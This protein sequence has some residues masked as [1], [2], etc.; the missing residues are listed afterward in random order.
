[1]IGVRIPKD[2]R[3]YKEKVALGMSLRQLLSLI[4]GVVIVAPIYYFGRKYV[5]EEII[6]WVTVLIAVPIIACGF[7]SINGMPL[8]RFIVRL[9]KNQF[10]Y[11]RKRLFKSKI[12]LKRVKPPVERTKKEQE[13]ISES[14]F[15][16]LFLIKESDERGEEK[17]MK[18]IKDE[19]LLTVRKS[20]K[21]RKKEKKLHDKKYNK[22]QKKHEKVSAKDKKFNVLKESA[23]NIISKQERD[24]EYIYTRKESRVVKKYKAETQKRRKN[25]V[26]KGVTEIK[27]KNKK[28]E[29]R[30]KAKTLIPKTA[31]ATLPYKTA[32]EDGLFE[33]ED[34]VYSKTFVLRNINFKIA[35]ELEQEQTFC[36]WGEFLN[37]FADD[38]YFSISIDNRV[39]SESEM[40]ENIHYRPT[41]DD[42]D[43]H[44]TEYNKIM[45]KAMEKSRKN[46]RQSIY[47]T[48][49]LSAENPYEANQKF[50][51]YERN[52]SN[53]LKTIGSACHLMTTTERLELIH[54]KMRSG[55]EGT[56]HIDYDF[57]ER[58]GLSS[59]DYVAPTSFSCM[60][61]K[62]YFKIDND[63][64]RTM[65]ISNMPTSL[66][67]DFI[68]EISDVDFP[69]THTICIQPI[70]PDKALKMVGRNYAGMEKDEL[71]YE[72]AAAKSGYS[73]PFL[74]RSLKQAGEQAEIL[75]DDIQNK[76]QKLFFV[77]IVCMVYGST[78]E[79][80]DANAAVL[81]GIARKFTCQLDNFDYQQE[82]GYKICFPTGINPKGKTYVDKA[83]TTEAAAIF[84]P[85]TT[86][87]LFQKHGYYYGINPLSN[88]LIMVDRFSFK[89]PSGFILG[90]SGSGKSFAC[91]REIINILLHDSKTNV[92][93]IDPENEYTT[94]CRMFGG[95]VINI[96]AGSDEHI[97]PMDMD[98]NYGLDENDNVEFVDM[99]TKKKKALAKKS[100]YI[101]SIVQSM[102]QDDNG[103]ILIT[104]A[105][106]SIVDRCVRQVYEEYL[107]QNFDEEYL[108][109]L[110][111]LWRAIAAERD[112][113]TEAAIIAESMEYFVQGS[114]SV[115]AQK[116][117]V[118]YNNRFVAFDIKEL[119]IQLTQ[120]GLLIILD[121]IWN[122]MSANAIHQVKTYCYADEIHVLFRNDYAASY[123][124][125]LYKRGRKFGLCITGITQDVEDLLENQM[126]RGMLS[127][128]DF[129]L[130][131]AQKT[132]NLQH[133][134]G[135]LHI[136]DDE[137][138]FV[139]KSEAGSG[140]LFAEQSIV[141]FSDHFP[142]TSYLYKLIS[143]KFGEKKSYE[144]IKAYVDDIMHEQQIHSISNETA[145]ENN[146]ETSEDEEDSKITA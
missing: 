144:E 38:V 57:L 91:K 134:Q 55:K 81:Q 34:G 22:N 40:Y 102:M 53:N 99:E 61:K 84:I 10:V 65:Y 106:K 19:D 98:E 88:N 29:K 110:V 112:V 121:F 30:R 130:M 39:I 139:T 129:I 77:T 78:K 75:L 26:E 83:L 90:S 23:E 45:D 116:T 49:S 101:M 37:Y 32:Y 122:R 54:D 128:S 8:E 127:N 48:L 15:E 120:I 135:L 66:T 20:R 111:D 80:L 56:F 24:P 126:A 96:S 3:E 60:D 143:T 73:K 92:L 7:F 108:P 118:D 13:Y 107:I 36:K 141:P 11:P 146:E 117:N 74:P 67:T 97:N 43:V 114:M 103:T 133:L 4:I 95:T 140:L 86:I 136:S 145:A 17:E 109:T 47:L 124:R 52:I 50:G 70:A 51:R 132:E 113:S 137:A 18:D 94:F 125:Q 138:K 16:K 59:K 104:P 93:I 69:V 21:Q 44:R 42:M 46:I 87:D 64:Y 142:E 35:D 71:K 14:T 82:D 9:W 5:N 6:S 62:D 33:V 63:Y 2:T 119:G 105:Q 123:I 115:F 79:E 76:S 25:E 100:D 68:E 41:G 85:F 58:S 28:M 131:L 72:K 1:M 12:S 31:Q 27:A 89:T